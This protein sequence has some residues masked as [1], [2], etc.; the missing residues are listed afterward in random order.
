MIFMPVTG[1]ILATVA[2][3]PSPYFWLFYWPQPTVSTVVAHVALQAHLAG[4]YLLYTLVGLHVAA[5][6]WHVAVR[7]DGTLE[8]MLPAQEGA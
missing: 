1:Y 5:V 4:Q 3:R 8:R 7:R 2:A 6:A